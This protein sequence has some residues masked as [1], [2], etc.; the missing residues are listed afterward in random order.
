M[1]YL[2]LLI[3]IKKEILK[4]KNKLIINGLTIYVLIIN[5][6]ILQEVYQSTTKKE[7][8]QYSVIKKIYYSPRSWWRD[9]LSE[10]RIN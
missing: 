2:I 3:I 7:N 6:Q 5:T 8:K 10:K 9:L 1:A 4:N